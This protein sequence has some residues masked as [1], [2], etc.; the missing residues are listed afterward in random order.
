M[1]IRKTAKYFIIQLF[2][3]DQDVFGSYMMSD[4]SLF[5]AHSPLNI[6]GIDIM[7]EDRVRRIKSIHRRTGQIPDDRETNAVVPQEFSY[8]L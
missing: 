8:A 2:N 5:N 1:P 6:R 4:S 7:L 3:I